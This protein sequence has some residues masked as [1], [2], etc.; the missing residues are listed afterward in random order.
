[1]F[2]IF[3]VFCGKKGTLLNKNH[4]MQASKARSVTEG[5]I[6]FFILEKWGEDGER[7]TFKAKKGLTKFG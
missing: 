5:T 3:R 7:T 2:R 4:L 1:M 6:A